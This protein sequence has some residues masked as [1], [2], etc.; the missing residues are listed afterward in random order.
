MNEFDKQMS[1]NQQFQFLRVYMRMVERL[2]QF[3]HTTR[4]RDWH[5]Y[6][7]ADEELYVDITSMDRLKYRRL[8]PVYMADMKHLDVFDPAVNNSFVEGTTLHS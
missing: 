1:G 3:I 6:L 2:F 4:A 5:F 7:S 8:L